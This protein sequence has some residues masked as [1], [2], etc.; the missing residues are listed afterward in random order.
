MKCIMVHAVEVYTHEAHTIIPFTY[1]TGKVYM[2]V[3]SNVMNFEI[4]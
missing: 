2:N 4:N 1:G 3:T